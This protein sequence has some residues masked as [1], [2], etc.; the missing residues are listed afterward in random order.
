[1]ADGSGWRAV[2]GVERPSV[3]SCRV[4]VTRARRSAMTQ[5]PL[6]SPEGSLTSSIGTVTDRKFRQA[7]VTSARAPARAAQPSGPTP[8]R[9]LIAH[10]DPGIRLAL[11]SCLEAEGYEIEE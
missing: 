5:Q 8:A 2:R 6:S 11:R 9:I 3:L 4:Q 1:M 7:V 10:D